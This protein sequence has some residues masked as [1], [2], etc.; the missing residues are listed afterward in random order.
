MQFVKISSRDVHY[1]RLF[2]SQDIIA[3]INIHVHYC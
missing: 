3:S 1:I 2:P